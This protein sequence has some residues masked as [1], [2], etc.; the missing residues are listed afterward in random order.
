MPAMRWLLAVLLPPTFGLVRSKAVKHK[1]SAGIDLKGR[2]MLA[3]NPI[4]GAIAFSVRNA[5]PEA[6]LA[7]VVPIS[8]ASWCTFQLWAI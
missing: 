5:F 7:R 8:V 3:R 1:S 4:R 2:Q 6:A